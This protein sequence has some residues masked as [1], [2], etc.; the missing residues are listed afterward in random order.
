MALLN[1]AAILADHHLTILRPLGQFL[2]QSQERLSNMPPARNTPLTILLTRRLS[3]GK[4]RT[5][6]RLRHPFSVMIHL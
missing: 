5:L 2:Q 1:T 6:S 4:T 3:T